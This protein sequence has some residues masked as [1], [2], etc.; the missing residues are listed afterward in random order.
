M[1]NSNKKIQ[2]NVKLLAIDQFVVSEIVEPVEKEVRD[3]DFITWGECNDYPDYIQNLYEHVST[4]KSVIDG[5]RDYV[6]G[7]RSF[8]N[9]LNF[10]DMINRKG[11]TFE[12]LLECIAA[13]FVKYN[14]FA[15][16]VVKNKLGT[17]AELYYL[18]FKKVRSNKEGTK[19]YYSDDWGKSYG[20]VKYTEYDSFLNPDAGVN[21]IFCFKNNVNTVYPLPM[22]AAAVVA[23]EIEKKLNEYHLTNIS[24]SFSSNYI[25]NFNSGRPSDEVQE[26]IEMEVYD[27][28]CGV[29]N[30]GRPM[31]SFNDSKDNETTVTKIDADSFIDKYNALAERTQQEIFTAFRATPNLFGIQTKTTGFSEQE[32][33]Q[34][35]KLFNKTVVKPMQK[36]I[37]KSFDKI[38]GMKN[39]ITIVPFEM[40]ALE[41]N[42]N[43]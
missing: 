43:E 9:A 5:T 29:E 41:E 32:Y 20:R 28:F 30:G 13:D 40:D 27:K 38:F 12:D 4:L 8:C 23:C 35:Y 25:I 10:K 11:Q 22:Y 19:Y 1:T 3:R 16:N 26:E 39:S 36:K 37:V 7:N 33:N 42:K 18:D 6:C 2:T 31:L 17:P 34:C 21:T 24:N 15:I 14:G